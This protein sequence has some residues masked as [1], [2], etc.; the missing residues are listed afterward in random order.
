MQIP[1]YIEAKKSARP[2]LGRTGPQAPTGPA[3]T[4]FIGPHDGLGRQVGVQDLE[5]VEIERLP[6][7]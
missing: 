4:G 7:E 2:A 3:Q 6:V 1:A 5:Q